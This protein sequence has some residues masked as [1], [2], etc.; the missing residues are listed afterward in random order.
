MI[1]DAIPDTSQPVHV[2]FEGGVTLE[3]FRMSSAKPTTESNLEIEFDWK[4]DPDVKPRMGI[5][6][7]LVPSKGDPAKDQIA[8]DHVLL[9]DIVEFEQAPA[10]KTI[11]DIVNVTIPFDAGGK[12]WTVYVG[13]WNVRGNGKRRAVTD[14]G[15]AT[16]DDNRVELGKF[17]VP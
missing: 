5:F 11:R 3:G 2:V 6:V 1:L 9:S 12:D 14:A 4:V 16:V 8:A 13:I 17:T 7:H 15:G 10:N